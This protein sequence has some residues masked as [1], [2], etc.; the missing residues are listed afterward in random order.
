MARVSAVRPNQVRVTSAAPGPPSPTSTSSGGGGLWRRISTNSQ[1]TMQAAP[2]SNTARTASP[3]V[4]V[5]WTLA[6]SMK[7]S[8]RA[9]ASARGSQRQPRSKRQASSAP[10]GT[11]TSAA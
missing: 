1:A 7:P 2:V 8:S 3:V 4:H 9:L 5:Y 11:P 6:L 10:S